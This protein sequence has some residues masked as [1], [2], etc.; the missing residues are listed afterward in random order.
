MG[1]QFSRPLGSTQQGVRGA[2]CPFGNRDDV[3]YLSLLGGRRKRGHPGPDRWLRGDAQQFRHS[4]GVLATWTPPVAGDQRPLAS[5]LR[6]LQ[7]NVQSWRGEGQSVLQGQRQEPTADENTPRSRPR[8]SPP[9]VC[10]VAGPWGN[11]GL[12]PN[13][14]VQTLWGQRTGKCGVE[15]ICLHPEYSLQGRLNLRLNLTNSGK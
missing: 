6:L 7:D 15:N 4:A 14:P 3:W 11:T 10:R 8:I 13:Y 5:R 1:S 12:A 2:V 9:G